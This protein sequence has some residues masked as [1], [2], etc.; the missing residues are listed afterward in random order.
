MKAIEQLL[1]SCGRAWVISGPAGGGPADAVHGLYVPFHLLPAAAGHDRPALV[2]DVHHELGGLVLGVAE[3]RLEDVRHVAHEVD[4]IVVD[5]RHPGHVGLG[6][7]ED[8][9]PT[10]SSR[11]PWVRLLVTLPMLPPQGAP[12]Q[13]ALWRG[14]MRKPGMHFEIVRLTE[15]G[16]TIRRMNTADLGLPVDVPSTALF[17]DQYE[18]TMLRAALKAG[19]AGRR[20]VFEV[21]TRRLPDGRR[22]GVV[23]GTGRVLDAVENFRFDRRARPALPART[24]HRRRGDPGLARRVPLPRGHLGLSRGRG[25]LPGLADHAGGGHLRRVRAAGPSPC[26]SSTTTRRSRPPPPACPRSPATGR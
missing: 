17:T 4:G 25:V 16:G 15:M 26:R 22:Y 7:G 1:P 5:D 23:A 6:Y 18:L 19:T 21:F 14:V 3:V 20:S 11:S 10:R 24:G 8:L 13:T 9:P 2:M 12:A